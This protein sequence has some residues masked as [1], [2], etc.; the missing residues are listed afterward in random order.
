MYYSPTGSS[1]HGFLLELTLDISARKKQIIAFWSISFKLLLLSKWIISQQFQ[2]LLSL[3]SL[4]IDI[5]SEQAVAILLMSLTWIEKVPHGLWYLTQVFSAS[6]LLVAQSCLT[7]CNPMAYISCRGPLSMGF[8][9]Q[10]YWSGLLCPPPG[11]LSDPGNQTPVS[12]I[13]GRF[14]TIWAK[15][16]DLCITVQMQNFAKQANKKTHY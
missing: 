15:R 8:S 11:D 13:A 9:R 5:N 3:F 12:H 2:C 7:L 4:Y 1:V 6:R 16:E 14:F 10:E